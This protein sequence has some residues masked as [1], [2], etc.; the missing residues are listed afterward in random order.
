VDTF[1]S[2]RVLRRET[3]TGRPHIALAGILCLLAL[4]NLSAQESTPGQSQPSMAEISKML[5][6]TGMLSDA[7]G[8]STG[9]PMPPAPG[10]ATAHVADNPLALDARA[11]G[12]KT[13]LACHRLEADHFSHTL[14][15]LGLH[16]ANRS[17]PRIPVCEACHGPGSQH[18]ASPG[19]PG[20]II[21]FTK[22][23]GTP[24]EVQTRTCLSCHGGGPRDHWLG[25]VHQRN[26]LSCSD[27]HN[28]MSK[29]S[30][31]GTMAKVSICSST[32]AR[33][34]RCRK[35]R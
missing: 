26:G 28:P 2:I 29:F 19:T 8:P 23:G 3:S 32:G 20:L 30:V 31:E 18:A 12:E 4:R 11:I 22:G 24:I 34:C 10:F 16:A 33:T 5:P 21:A 25:S 35:D 27:C 15:S 13:C 7:P 9:R 1:T 6:A 17:D 14:H